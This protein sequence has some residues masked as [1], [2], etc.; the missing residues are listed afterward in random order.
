MASPSAAG[1]VRFGGFQ[2]DLS[3]RE[4]RKGRSR[5]RVPDQ[6]LAILAM[7]P[8]RPG[9]LVGSTVQEFG[10]DRSASRHLDALTVEVNDPPD[11]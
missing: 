6:S 3:S 9:E 7:L 8:E 10:N 1:V 5:I 2:F 4:L 11:N